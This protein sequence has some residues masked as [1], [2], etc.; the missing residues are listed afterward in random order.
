MLPEEFKK[1]TVE[2]LLEFNNKQKNV[3]LQSVINGL[4][5]ATYTPE[6]VST[7]LQ[8]TEHYDIIRNE[9]FNKTFPE[10]VGLFQ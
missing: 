8:K 9:N 10:L 7:F 2:K 6:L 3:N 1:Q 5:S 4:T